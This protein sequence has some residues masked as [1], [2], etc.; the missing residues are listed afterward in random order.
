ML[1]YIYFSS[2]YIN[3]VNKLK[4]KNASSGV[5]L[6][7]K[8]KKLRKEKGLTQSEL[9]GDFITRSMLSLIENG[10]AKPSRSTVAYI[11]DKL[12]VSAGYFF[13]DGDDPFSYKKSSLIDRIKELFLKKHYEAVISLCLSLGGCDDEIALILTECYYKEGASKYRLGKFDD[14]DKY[15]EEAISYSEKTVYSTDAI[16]SDIKKMLY[17]SELIRR[18]T[19]SPKYPLPSGKKDSERLEFELYTYI[20]KVIE[21]SRYDIAAQIYDTMRFSNELYKLHISAR[22]SLASRNP[23]RAINL[24]E[25]IISRFEECLPDAFFKYSIISDLEI[26]SRSASDFERAYKY[27]LMR[28][29]FSESL[30]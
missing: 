28:Q 21:S 26:A 23:T 13:D 6:G 22:L 10:R 7:D 8:I 16:I 18:G 2:N 29:E 14:A 15:F 30:R 19:Y 17:L 25:E 27:A 5:S 4:R 11:A 3:E 24:L 1:K 12:G 9:C 20:L